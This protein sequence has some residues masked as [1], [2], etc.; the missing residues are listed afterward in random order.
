MNYERAIFIGLVLVALL[1]G[2]LGYWAGQ[3]KQ[4]DFEA[5]CET[6]GVQCVIRFD[7]DYLATHGVVAI[8]AYVGGEFAD[9]RAGA[10]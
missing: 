4:R 6:P 7:P 9:L 8:P 3:G 1:I 10:R 5:L 2:P